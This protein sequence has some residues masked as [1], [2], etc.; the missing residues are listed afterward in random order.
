M[1]I[2]YM[3][4]MD[5]QHIQGKIVSEHSIRFFFNSKYVYYLFLWNDLIL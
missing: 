5:Q 1:G 3:A 2:D 4:D